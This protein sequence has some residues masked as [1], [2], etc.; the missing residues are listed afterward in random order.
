MSTPEVLANKILELHYE[1]QGGEYKA[2]EKEALVKIALAAG[3]AA[4]RDWPSNKVDIGKP[5]YA[6]IAGDNPASGASIETVLESPAEPEDESEE[7]AEDE[8]EAEPTD[9][10]ADVQCSEEPE[11]AE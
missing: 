8:C 9:G 5:L 7:P 6:F 10:D 3:E 1:A 2:G 4:E 11:D